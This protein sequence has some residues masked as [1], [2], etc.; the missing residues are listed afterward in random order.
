MDSPHAMRRTAALIV[1]LTLLFSTG[2]GAQSRISVRGNVGAAFFQSPNGLNSI[3]NSGVDLGLGTSVRLYEGLELVL[4]GS[5]DR[6]T[7]NGDNVAVFSRNLQVG[8]SSRIEGG[9]YSFLNATI[10]MR[11][12]YR[13]QSSAHPYMSSGVGLYRSA[14]AETKVFQGGRLVQSARA[15]STVS[16]GFHLSLGVDFRINDTYSFFFEPRYVVVNTNDRKF[17][18]ETSSQYVPIRLGLDVRL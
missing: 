16:M 3:L 8:P 15:R 5:Y 4:Q 7:L 13:N 9:D 17:G 11:Y 18:I 2:A 1:V 6:F 14:V 12:V 10:G